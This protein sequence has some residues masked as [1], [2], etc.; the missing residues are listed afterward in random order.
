MGDF[1]PFRA[2]LTGLMS[3]HTYTLRMAYGALIS[4]LHAY[5]YLGSYNASEYPAGLLGR[6]DPCGAVGGTGGDH[7][8][9]GGHGPD[10]TPIPDD[11]RTT[12]PN[13]L[14]REN[15][16]DFAAW[17]ATFPSVGEPAAFVNPG[18]TQITVDTTGTVDRE[19]EV[20][21]RADGGTVVLAWGAHV[22]SALDWGFGRTYAQRGSGNFYMYL[23]QLHQH[24]TGTYITGRVNRT[25]SVSATGRL[26][27]FTTRVSETSVVIGQTVVDTATLGG[28][29]GAPVMGELRFFVCGPDE[30]TRPDCSHGGTPTNPPVV[31]LNSSPT[32]PDGH[33]SSEFVPSEPGHYCFRVEYTPSRYAAYSPAVHTDTM[34]EC[35]DAVLARLTVV[36]LCVPPGDPGLFDLLANNEPLGGGEGEDV[37]CGDSRGPFTKTAT[38]P[39]DATSSALP[40]TTPGEYTIGVAGGT[41]TDLGHYDMEIGGNCNADGSITLAPGDDKECVITSTREEGPDDTGEGPGD[42]DDQVA[43]LTLTKTCL[44]SSDGGKFRFILDGVLHRVGGVMGTEDVPIASLSCGESTAAP[45]S[46][47]LGTYTVR[48]IGLPPTSLADYTTAVSCNGA[49][50]GTINFVAGASVHCTFTNTRIRSTTTS[51]VD[52]ACL[53]ATDTGRFNLTINGH[54]AGTGSDVGCGGTTGAVPVVPGT[55]RVGELGAG[56]TVLANYERI[57]GNDCAADGTVTVAAGQHKTCLISNVRRGTPFAKLAVVKI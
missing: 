48:E 6:V 19:I 44:P 29:T 46:V 22:A 38:T 42:P 56:G 4:G 5:D 23:L 18:R 51:R 31:A 1:V 7:R 30:L 20:T 35:F 33:G 41:N 2:V 8:C 16:G 37:P 52:K 40:R 14:H 47:G 28:R 53:P 11:T 24:N 57:V 9:E 36:K 13:G 49:P 32:N 34:D 43:S 21:F 27:S 26:T 15:T 3:G 45:V 50:P 39:P 10:T 25:L 17:G 55:Y 12:F 54:V